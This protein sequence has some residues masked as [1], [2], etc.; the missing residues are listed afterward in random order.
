MNQTVNEIKPI[1]M[2]VVGIATGLADVEIW[3]KIGVGLAT[4]V[5]VVV[6]TIKLLQ[7]GPVKP[8]SQEGL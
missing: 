8:G 5:Y 1:A 4:T 6:R 3:V 2:A 7:S